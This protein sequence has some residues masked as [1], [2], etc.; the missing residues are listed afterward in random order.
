MCRALQH[1]DNAIQILRGAALLRCDK[2]STLSAGLAAEEIGFFS[3]TC[4]AAPLHLGQIVTSRRD[5]K[6]GMRTRLFAT[7]ARY[8]LFGRLDARA[9][10]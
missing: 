10:I 1:H 8:A 3:A 6:H 4:L 9:Y 2:D 5:P 7:V